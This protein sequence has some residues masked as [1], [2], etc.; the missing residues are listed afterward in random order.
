MGIYKVGNIWYIDYYCEGRRMREP[1]SKKKT[2]AEEMLEA[3]K[4]DIVRGEFHLP[5]KR[6]IKFEKF[7]Q[8]Y[9]EY[10]KINKRS[11]ERDRV[12]LGHLMPHFK[13]M[14][15][16]K[17]N[18]KHIEDYKRTRLKRVRPVTINRELALLKYMFSLARK[19]KYTNE[20]PVKEVKFFQETQYIMRVLNETEIKRLVNATEGYPRAIIILALNTAMR[21][22]EILNLRWNDVDFFKEYICIKETKSNL[23][24]KIP[25]NSVVMATLNSIERKGD[26]VF[27]GGEAGKPYADI[28]YPF[29]AA[30]KKVGIKDLRFHDLRHT[31][32]TLMV[33]GGIDLVTVSKILGHADIKMTMRYAHPTPENK[34]NAVSVLASIF[35]GKKEKIATIQ[36]QEERKEDITSLLSDSK[37]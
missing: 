5:G 26:Y 22:G 18:P 12:I 2:E 21:K 13:G 23:I 8:E 19:W 31:A 7:A 6:K 29:K 37:N 25:M 24:R 11:W 35:T 15:L 27:S 33:T 17:I 3:R 20:N 1:A 30:C 14:A 36:P 34:R 32:A 16:S 4:T 10:A 28:F 9:L